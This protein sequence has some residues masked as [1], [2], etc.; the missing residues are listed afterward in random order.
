MNLIINYNDGDYK[1]ITVS[2][3]KEALDKIEKLNLNNNLLINGFAIKNN[4]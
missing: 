2:S 1:K 4:F 3:F